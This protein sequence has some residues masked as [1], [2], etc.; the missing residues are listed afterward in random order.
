MAINP[1][2]GLDVLNAG[3]FSTWDCVWGNF[4]QIWNDD[5]I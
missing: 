2:L 5:G 3:I 1:I 4:S